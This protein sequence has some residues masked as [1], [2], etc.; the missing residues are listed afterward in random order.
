VLIAP[1]NNWWIVT[2]VIQIFGIK[3]QIQNF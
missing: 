1:R 3:H 2:H